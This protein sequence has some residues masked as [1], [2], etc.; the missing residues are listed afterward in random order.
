MSILTDRT[1][2]ELA[3]ALEVMDGFP[4]NTGRLSMLD[5]ATLAYRR[6]SPRLAELQGAFGNARSAHMRSWSTEAQAYSDEAW[7]AAMICGCGHHLSF[8]DREA[9]SCEHLEQVY[10]GNG[11]YGNPLACTCRQYSGP[12]PMPE[13]YA[14][15]ITS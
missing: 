8:H 10:L 1:A 6:K 5:E 7:R 13:Y 12:Q 4:H 11:R 9:G 15:E 3:D 2:A 14:P